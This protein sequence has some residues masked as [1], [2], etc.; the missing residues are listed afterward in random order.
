MSNLIILK[1]NVHTYKYVHIYIYTVW[2]LFIYLLFNIYIYII[3]IIIIIIIILILLLLII[4]IIYT[5]QKSVKHYGTWH[6]PRHLLSILWPSWWPP[7]HDSRHVPRCW[8]PTRPWA[9]GN[10]FFGGIQWDS[11][12]LGAW[13]VGN[14]E[15]EFGFKASKCWL[16]SRFLGGF[17]TVGWSLVFR[18]CCLQKMLIA[19]FN[20]LSSLIVSTYFPAC[21][22][23]LGTLPQQKALGWRGTV[24]TG[25]GTVSTAQRGTPITGSEMV[26]TS[27][28]GSTFLRTGGQEE[29]WEHS[30]R[31]FKKKQLRGRKGRETTKMA[32]NVLRRWTA[33][34]FCEKSFADQRRD[35]SVGWAWPPYYLQSG[36]PDVC[37]CS[38]PGAWH[39][40]WTDPEWEPPLKPSKK[41]QCYEL[42]SHICIS[43]MIVVMILLSWSGLSTSLLIL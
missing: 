13:G 30:K 41:L 39:P 23:I 12:C 1:N 15:G 11:N 24:S 35:V 18:G 32:G 10:G 37:W 19:Q 6:L 8:F 16:F 21:F 36:S 43:V 40:A 4:I 26:S 2:Y 34:R 14:S 17:L 5:V 42:A 7:S 20:F 31:S 22:G 25:R 38:P 29:K 3:I 28:R 27:W 33:W 9:P